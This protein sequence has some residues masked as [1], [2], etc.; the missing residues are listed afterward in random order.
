MK[1]DVTE[2]VEI[3]GSMCAFECDSAHYEGITTVCVRV[4][5]RV[6]SMDAV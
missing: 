1:C 3:G 4:C 2:R 6:C 5:I